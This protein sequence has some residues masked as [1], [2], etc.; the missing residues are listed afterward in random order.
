MRP[1]QKKALMTNF[2]VVGL[3][4]VSNRELK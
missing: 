1:E 2:F 4:V 3:M